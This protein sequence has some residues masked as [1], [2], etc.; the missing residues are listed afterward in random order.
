MTKLY[1]EWGI[2]GGKNQKGR[3]AA[4]RHKKQPGCRDGFYSSL[5]VLFDMDESSVL[6][7]D[8]LRSHS[9]M[10]LEAVRVSL[11]GWS[12]DIAGH[13]MLS[14]RPFPSLS[15]SF[16][17]AL[18]SVRLQGHQ[19]KGPRFNE[20]EGPWATDLALVRGLLALV[21][22]DWSRFDGKVELL[23]EGVC[24]FTGCGVSHTSQ[25]SS[26]SKR[27]AS[28]LVLW[29]TCLFLAVFLASDAGS[30]ASIPYSFQKD[31]SGA[32]ALLPGLVAIMEF[33]P[34]DRLFRDP[35]DRSRLCEVPVPWV[36]RY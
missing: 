10:R 34:V 9:A 17:T 26:I 4:K 7:G 5:H 16:C 27:S 14:G 6:F 25:L 18:K 19:P 31:I 33:E 28:S 36:L 2:K 12:F 23:D 8:R 1:M 29:F 32:A 22:G 3:V 30:G 24:V 13:G 35:V 11:D 21:H 20:L 15:V